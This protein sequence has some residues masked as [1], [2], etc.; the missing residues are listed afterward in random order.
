ML[1]CFVEMQPTPDDVGRI[2]KKYT[3]L[4]NSDP[5]HTPMWVVA[6]SRGDSIQ[7]PGVRFSEENSPHAGMSLAVRA[8][9]IILNRAMVPES[10]LSTFLHEYGHTLFRDEHG[11]N[12]SEVASE[13]E[14]IRFSLEALVAE[15]FD[16]MAYREA[17]NVKQMAGKEPYK[18]AV[19]CLQTDPLWRKYARLSEDE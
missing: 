6:A 7:I 14:A 19:A 17:N 13:V 3:D 9:L 10:L 5:K 18:S 1:T 16:E 12:P 8:E 4:W 2:I 15:G 11:P